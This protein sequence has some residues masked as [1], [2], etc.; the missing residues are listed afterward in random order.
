M[1]LVVLLLAVI[2]LGG[3]LIGLGYAGIVNIPGITPKK[4]AKKPQAAQ[5]TP[6]QPAAQEIQQPALPEPIKEPEIVPQKDGTERLA[7]LWA[8]L[9]A[10]TLRDIYLKYPDGDA[11]AVLAKMD[12][13]KVSALLA[14]LPPDKAAQVSKAIKSLPKGGK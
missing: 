10:E 6:E 13:A 7:K 3:T 4:A 2:A 5:E 14:V 1:K 12:D 11:L 9:D 8:T